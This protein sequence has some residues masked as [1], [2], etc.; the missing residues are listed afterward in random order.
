MSRVVETPAAVAPLDLICLP[1]AG[2]NAQ[3]YRG[4]AERLPSTVRVRPLELPGHGARLAHPLHTDWPTLIETLLADVLKH[5]DI[6]GRFAVF[7]HSM[8]ALVGL[9]L[10]HAIRRRCA[11]SPVWFGASA[12]VAPER[13]PLEAHWLDC[14]HEAMVSK[15]RGLG[16]TPDALMNDR[17]FIQFMLPVLRADFHLCGTYAHHAASLSTN[18]RAP[19][20]CPIGVFTGRDDSATARAEDVAAWS[21]QT[22]GVCTQHRFDGG[23]FFLDATPAPVL[24]VVATSLADA[25]A[26]ADCRVPADLTQG[27]A[28][29]H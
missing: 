29:I 20:D 13:R 19:L 11:R 15:L 3:L 23:H 10:I 26:N 4:W 5:V 21:A 1:H 16:G 17:E 28:W 27:E 6:N 24:T 25:P 7:G 2:G 8:G 22:H 18:E 14:T 12:C 9:E